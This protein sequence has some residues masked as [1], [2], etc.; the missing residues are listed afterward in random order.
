ADLLLRADVCRAGTDER[1]RSLRIARL[2]SVINN[3]IV[4]W[5]FIAFA[6]FFSHSGP[7]LSL[8]AKTLLGAGTTAGVVLQGI[9]LVPFLRADGLRFRPNLKD[10]AIA[11]TL[12]LSGYA[13]G[14]ALENQIGLWVVLVLADRVRG[15]VTSWNAAYQFFTFPYGIF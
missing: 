8:A 2:R 13:L 3:V 12:R 9:V 14:Y 10:P 4:I 15:G 11:R 6:H 1:P 7:H 5:T